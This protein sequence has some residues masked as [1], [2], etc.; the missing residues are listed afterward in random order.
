MFNYQS[1]HEH[2]SLKRWDKHTKF[3]LKITQ[4][5][6]KLW[7]LD[8]LSTPYQLLKSFFKIQ[9]LVN[10]L[11]IHFLYLVFKWILQKVS[12]KQNHSTINNSNFV[13]VK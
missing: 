6:E 5:F 13:L 7:T 10:K 2:P 9:T 1:F 4:P 8:S 12:T 11:F 3:V